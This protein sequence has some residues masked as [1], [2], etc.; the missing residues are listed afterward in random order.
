ML[1]NGAQHN[2]AARS[3][4]RVVWGHL[5]SKIVQPRSWHVFA[6]KPAEGTGNSIT[7]TPLRYFS[8]SPAVRSGDPIRLIFSHTW[9][10]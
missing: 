8:V 7:S 9:Q 3:R 4:F 6:H 1:A 2:L 10:S 5:P